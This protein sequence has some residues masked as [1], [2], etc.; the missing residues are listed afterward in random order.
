MPKEPH[1]HSLV[2]EMLRSKLRSLAEADRLIIPD[3]P[4]IV[5][6]VT[7][8]HLYTSVRGIVKKGTTLL[9]LIQT[10]HATPA[11]SGLST[12]PYT[13]DLFEKKKI[14]IADGMLHRLSE[15]TLTTTMNLI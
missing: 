1:E 2:V 3:E 9:D 15:L 5:R 13:K 7:L 12:I 6:L 14:W 4:T 8:Q 10:L 11:V